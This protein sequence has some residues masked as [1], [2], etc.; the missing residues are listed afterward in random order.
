MAF[1]AASGNAMGA[2]SSWKRIQTL[3]KD[4]SKVGRNA[5]RYPTIILH[6]CT[7][8]SFWM[9]LLMQLPQ[10]QSC[11]KVAATKQ[12]APDL[13]EPASL[14]L[15]CW[16]SSGDTVAGHYQEV[17]ELQPEHLVFSETG[18]V[19]IQNGIPSCT[20]Q[21]PKAHDL[22]LTISSSLVPSLGCAAIC[23]IRARKS[24]DLSRNGNKRT[25]TPTS[26]SIIRDASKSLRITHAQKTWGRTI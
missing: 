5:T 8:W 19:V 16:G 2:C 9:H 25:P 14:V 24:R 1:E 15:I 17:I 3:S 13:L 20:Q 21:P 10:W 12:T 4:M 26:D 6:T 18:S 22:K 7:C 11:F 23:A